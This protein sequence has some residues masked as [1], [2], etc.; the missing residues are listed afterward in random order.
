MNKFYGSVG[1]V[2]QKEISPGVW[3]NQIVERSYRGDVLQ[4]MR[5]WQVSEEKNDDLV[6][7]N[8]ISI[9]ADP[10]AYENL[11]TIRYIYLEGVR[12]K[13]NNI[14]IQRPRL[15]LTLGEVYNGPV[16]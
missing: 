7:S 13:V 3:D 12:W 4:N 8:R 9:I 16:K 10:F 6:L 5:R 2:T 14:E 1:Y 15:I 11:S